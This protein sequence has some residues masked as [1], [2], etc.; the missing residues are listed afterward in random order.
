MNYV[1][2]DK[3]IDVAYLPLDSFIHRIIGRET[4]TMQEL[5]DITLF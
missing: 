1:L 3:L 4:Y 5:K 2:E